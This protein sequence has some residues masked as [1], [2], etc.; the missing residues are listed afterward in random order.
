M[1][2][3]ALT[4]RISE[5]GSVPKDLLFRSGYKKLEGVWRG[6][7][8]V[9]WSCN[10]G[11]RSLGCSLV[12][13]Y[14]ALVLSGFRLCDLLSMNMLLIFERFLRNAMLEGLSQCLD[15]DVTSRTRLHHVSLLRKKYD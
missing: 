12:A 13:G 15:I 6:Y 5:S 7:P 9:S 11:I 1:S 2:L 4:G 8:A 14:F 3:L 10:V